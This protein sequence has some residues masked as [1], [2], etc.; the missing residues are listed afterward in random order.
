MHTTALELQRDAQ[1]QS[2]PLEVIFKRNCD[3]L[4]P[5]AMWETSSESEM[6]PSALG[7]MLPFVLE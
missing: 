3:F 5:L 4:F 6:L 7:I 1:R 2:S